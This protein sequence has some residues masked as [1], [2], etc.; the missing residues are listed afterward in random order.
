[1]KKMR[2]PIRSKTIILIIAFALALNCVA[3]VLFWR[4]IS[5]SDDRRYKQQAEELAATVAAVVDAEMFERVRDKVLA[6]YDASPE[7]V[8]SDEWGSDAWNDYMRPFVPVERSGD[9]MLLRNDLRKIQDVNDVDCVYLVTVDSVREYAI[10]VVDAAYEDVCPPGCI[11]A[12]FD[13]NRPVIENPERGFPAYISNTE[14]Y[15]WLVTAGKPIHAKDGSVLG[16]AAV[17]ISMSAVKHAQW[18][19]VL[20]LFGYLAASMVIL[21]LIGI[22]VVTRILVRPIRTLTD[23]VTEYANGE[24][25][26]KRTVFANVKLNTRDELEDLAESMKRME[27]EI[28]DNIAELL[29]VNKKLTISRNVADRMTEL[30]NKDALTGV[31]NKNAYDNKAE[32]M[33]N[34]LRTDPDT[35]FGIAM[36]DLN[37][38]K[39][40][41]DDYGHESGDAAIIKL[42]DIVCAVFAHSQVFR[43]GGDEFVVVL[44]KSDYEDA[45][46]LI[47]EF[48][49][50]MDDL[51]ADDDLLPQEKAS[52]ALG[53]AAYDPAVDSSVADVLKRADRAMYER[54]REMK[55]GRS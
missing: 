20:K 11:D 51:A 41:N 18:I 36:V 7:K 46:Y 32:R 26:A 9:F 33:E 8:L 43:V 2:L 10:Y 23:A 39:E 38:L 52:A 22:A 16:Y 30:A 17:D 6:I 49:R 35:K 37:N 42:C 54:K 40:I 12:F 1:M 24:P 48:N 55:V 27:S 14:E 25:N 21:C 29:A 31:R 44:Q 13:Y 19:S 47:D 50:K 15:G 4:V 3:A 5:N 34:A 28:N 53:Y 45:Q